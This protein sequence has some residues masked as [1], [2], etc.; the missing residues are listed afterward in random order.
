MAIKDEINKPRLTD[1]QAI[2]LVISIV[3]FVC[4]NTDAFTTLDDW[5]KVAVYAGFTVSIALSGVQIG[6]VKQL[7]EKGLAIF[8]DKNKTLEQKYNELFEAFLTVAAQLGI[9]HESWN[10]MQGTSPIPGDKT[11]FKKADPNN[12]ITENEVLL[13]G[14]KQL[15]NDITDDH[16]KIKAKIA[17]LE[18]T[19]KKE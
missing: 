2:M 14:L 18:A 16:P 6:S 17:E 13:D 12:P 1:F 11:Y 5:I 19:L 7:V 3:F 8:T 9:I 4:L 10:L 15:D